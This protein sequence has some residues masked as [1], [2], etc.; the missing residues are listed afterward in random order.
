MEKFRITLG[1]KENI[2][3]QHTQVF[4]YGLLF[5]RALLRFSTVSPSERSENTLKNKDRMSYP[6]INSTN[7]FI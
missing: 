6:D 7:S 4:L 3:A 5:P 2:V 1:N